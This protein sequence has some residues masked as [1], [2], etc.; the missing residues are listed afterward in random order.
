MSLTDRLKALVTYSNEKTG[1]SDA[2]LSDAVKHLAE[3]YGG[4]GDITLGSHKVLFRQFTPTARSHYV[5][6]WLKIPNTK[7]LF[8]TFWLDDFSVADTYKA[9]GRSILL[10]GHTF[11]DAF[12]SNPQKSRELRYRDESGIM[13]FTEHNLFGITVERSADEL[14]VRIYQHQF[15][16][17][18]QAE[19]YNY[20]VIYE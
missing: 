19:L 2:T 5:T 13:K 10:E 3:G 17:P 8:A 18:L 1:K 15:D 11:G 9:T 6:K 12:G 20:M 7:W 4:G 14:R 16:Y